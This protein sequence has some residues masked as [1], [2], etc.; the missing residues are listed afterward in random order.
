MFADLDVVHIGLVVVGLVELLRILLHLVV[1]TQKRSTN[2]P[3]SRDEFTLRDG[4]SSLKRTYTRNSKVQVDDLATTPPAVPIDSS[5]AFFGELAET[6]AT[7][8]TCAFVT[9]MLLPL[10]SLLAIDVFD[11]ETE[12]FGQEIDD[13]NST[14]E[15]LLSS[16]TAVNLAYVFAALFILGGTAPFFVLYYTSPTFRRGTKQILGIR[17]RFV[18]NSTSKFDRRSLHT[19]ENIDDTSVVMKRASSVPDVQQRSQ[20]RSSMQRERSRRVVRRSRSFT[21]GRWQP[22]PRPPSSTLD[23]NKDIDARYAMDTDE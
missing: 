23:Q 5:R 13:L 16:H 18:E 17:I 15:Y 12:T 22:Q 19:S 4:F 3:G 2:G 1:E 6:R 10:C 11:V 20:K 21:I 7:L 9:L 14:S 8:I